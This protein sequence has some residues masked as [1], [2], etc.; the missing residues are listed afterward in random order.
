M[1]LNMCISCC[2]TQDDKESSVDKIKNSE[3]DGSQVSMSAPWVAQYPS[4]IQ[5]QIQTTN[6]K[7]SMEEHAICLKSVIPLRDAT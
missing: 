6:T 2:E 3:Q 4:L 5:R 1:H 7:G